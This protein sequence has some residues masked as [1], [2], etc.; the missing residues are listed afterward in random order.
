[1]AGEPTC[2]DGYH[3]TLSG[4]EPDDDTGPEDLSVRADLSGCT[5]ACAGATPYCGLNHSCVACL[6]GTLHREAMGRSSD[7]QEKPPLQITKFEQDVDH[8][9]VVAAN[10]L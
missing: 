10:V 8:L 5:P 6:Q 2:P 3:C 1:M 7:I 4:C 9:A